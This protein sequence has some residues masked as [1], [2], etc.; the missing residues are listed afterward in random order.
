[1]KYYLTIR[2]Q[3]LKEVWE[4]NNAQ[5]LLKIV[6]NLKE[7]K[8]ISTSWYLIIYDT[9]EASGGTEILRKRLTDS[10]GADISDLVAGTLT[11]ELETSV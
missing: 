1:M 4:H 9:G 2:E 10:T 8:K 5:F 11:A 3:Q 7:L 6:R